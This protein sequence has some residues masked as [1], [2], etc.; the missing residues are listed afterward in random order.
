MSIPVSSI[1]TR[2]R[3]SDDQ[4]LRV[5]RD[6]GSYRIGG[7]REDRPQ[8]ERRTRDCER[9]ERYAREIEQIL[10]EPRE[11]LKLTPQYVAGAIRQRR[12]RTR[13]EQPLRIRD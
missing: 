3:A 5:L 8:V 2:A 10:D 11:M 1:V 12:L 4:F 6:G 9:A 7:V 13:R